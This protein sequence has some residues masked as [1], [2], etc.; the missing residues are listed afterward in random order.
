[1]TRSATRRR[2]LLV[3]ADT[4]LAGLLQAWLDALDCDVV[5]DLGARD[6]GCDAAI[7]DIPFPRQEGRELVQ[8]ILRRHPDTPILAVSSMFFACV[9]CFGQVSRAL[10]VSC[11]LPKPLSR[12]ALLDAVR[13]LLAH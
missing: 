11:V 3:G 1:M 7:V 4:E 8:D 9:E 10:G 6:A 13:R 12:E 5:D 2:V